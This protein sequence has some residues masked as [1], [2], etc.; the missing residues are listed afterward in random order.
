MDLKIYWL[1]LVGILALDPSRV[2]KPTSTKYIPG[3]P[4]Q[5][6]FDSEKP[7]KAAMQYIVEP[8]IENPIPATADFMACQSC[9]VSAYL[10]QIYLST[11]MIKTEG[12]LT[13]YAVCSVAM[14]IT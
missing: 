6:I 12:R 11:W 13:L 1:L 9:Q 8:L 5:K 4:I 2:Q 3:H 14:V 7:L 10:F